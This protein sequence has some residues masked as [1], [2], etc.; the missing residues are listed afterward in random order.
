MGFDEF[1]PLNKN[2]FPLWW[3]IGRSESEV[4]L[5]HLPPP[6]FFSLSLFELV[7]VLMITV[8]LYA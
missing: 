7:F 3:A 5:P 2:Y 6:P 4:K 8:G 1:I